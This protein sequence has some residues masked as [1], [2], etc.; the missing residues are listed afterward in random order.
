MKSL[1]SFP[2]SML[3]LV[4]LVPAAGVARNASAQSAATPYCPAATITPAR[5]AAAA[6]FSLSK[7]RE[8]TQLNSNYNVTSGSGFNYVSMVAHRGIWEFCPESTLESYE[9]ALDLGVE[10]VEMDFRLSAPGFNPSEGVDYPNGEMFLTHD[11]SLRGEA[12][13]LDNV[14][15]QNVIY[16]AAPESLSNR[17]MVDR[18]GRPAYANN[19]VP[20]PVPA[21]SA[22]TAT[23]PIVLHSLT[24]L[25]TH[26]LAKA[27]A[28]GATIVT[29][30]GNQGRDLMARGPELV[31]DIKGGEP[32]LNAGADDTLPNVVCATNPSLK[33]CNSTSFLGVQEA[34]AEVS[35]FEK[36][37][38]VDLTQMIV[39]KF[40]SKNMTSALW[41]G[42]VNT[43]YLGQPN[44]PGMV[45]IAYNQGDNNPPAEMYPGYQSYPGY[46]ITNWN[47]QYQGVS[48][49]QWNTA[50]LLGMSPATGIHG[51]ESFQA[52]NGFPEGSRWSAGQ[53]CH[54]PQ[55][56]QTWGQAAIE[57]NYQPPYSPLRPFSGWPYNVISTS[58]TL[59]AYGNANR[60]LTN[61]GL[62]FTSQIQ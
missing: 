10:G 22:C 52:S 60:Y 57:F 16:A 59:D 17:P 8:Y 40:V 15:P 11:I 38:N 9:A 5:A 39:Y 31:L 37:N 26:I 51:T 42:L 18:N 58:I 54:D 41:N 55:A 61:R 13:D 28:N 50:D 53:C 24:Y 4:I 27:R 33:Y 20:V 32:E 47:V 49:W 14:N 12:P 7:I 44:Q 19:C 29:G 45:L 46:L 62:R 25:L 1:R 30:G 35:A 2:L 21:T 6:T 36:A 3:M 23:T 43:Y 34:I 56:L 48:T